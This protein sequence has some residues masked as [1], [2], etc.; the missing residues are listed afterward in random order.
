MNLWRKQIAGGAG[1]GGG[2]GGGIGG[3]SHEKTCESRVATQNNS[4][5]GSNIENSGGQAYVA[6]TTLLVQSLCITYL[7]VP[8][9][10][11]QITATTV[12]AVATPKNG[13]QNR[14]IPRIG[15][16]SERQ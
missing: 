8:S 6:V 12:V 14:S 10:G 4:K 1:G 9:H 3:G 11:G 5:K 7:S 2:G 16:D 15:I 13:F